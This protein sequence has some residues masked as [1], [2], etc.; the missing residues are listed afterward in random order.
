MN[1][2]KNRLKERDVSNP[3]L[4]KMDPSAHADKGIINGDKIGVH[5]K[6]EKSS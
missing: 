6:K 4:R 1:N 5:G 3:T 2:N